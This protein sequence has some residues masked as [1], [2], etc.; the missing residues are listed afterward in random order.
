MRHASVVCVGVFLMIVWSAVAQETTGGLIGAVTNDVGSPI[1][2]ALV[3]ATG[4]VGKVSSTSDS[5]GKYRF[6]RLAL[7]DYTRVRQYR[8]C[9]VR[10]DQ[11]PRDSR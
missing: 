5:A 8:G 9:G 6:P 3:V 10:R 11:G 1:D 4:P 2:G 7:G